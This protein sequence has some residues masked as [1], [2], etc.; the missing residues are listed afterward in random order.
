MG[1]ITMVTVIDMEGRGISF[2]AAV[3]QVSP[4]NESHSEFVRVLDRV[5]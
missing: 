5:K 1:A 4:I 2:H 3:I